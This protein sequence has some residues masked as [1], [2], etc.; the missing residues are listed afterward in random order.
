MPHFLLNFET[1]ILG[2]FF[3]SVGAKRHFELE[4]RRDAL[5]LI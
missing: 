3:L 5:S 2:V 1:T 4:L